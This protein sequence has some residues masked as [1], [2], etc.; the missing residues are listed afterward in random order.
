VL[1][2]GRREELFEAKDAGAYEGAFKRKKSGAGM[3][4]FQ[5]G[6]KRF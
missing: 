1:G 6:K 2:G 5:K 3:K 4:E